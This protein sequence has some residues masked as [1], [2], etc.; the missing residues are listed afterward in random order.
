MKRILVAML[1]LA[2]TVNAALSPN[3][4]Y[5]LLRRYAVRAAQKAKIVKA[6]DITLGLKNPSGKL[7]GCKLISVA[8][9]NSTQVELI[10]KTPYGQEAVRVKDEDIARKKMR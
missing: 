3:E 2:A 6:T 5:M 8:P 7:K 9:V 4:T 10:Y 1:L